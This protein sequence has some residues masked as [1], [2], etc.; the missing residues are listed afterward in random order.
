L[1]RRQ[2]PRVALAAALA[3]VAVLA[4]TAF[5]ATGALTPRGCVDDN[6]TG[7]DDCG[8]ST[9]GLAS[10]AS[11]AASPDGRSVYTA[12]STDNAIV[13]FD[14]DP[15]TG[16][17]TPQGCIEDE[18]V[19]PDDCDQTAPGLEGAISVAVSPDGNSV[20]AASITD[21]AVVRFDRDSSGALTQQGCFDDNDTGADNCGAGNE[22]NG[23]D[24]AASAT[25]SPD[26]KS[27]YV[28]SNVDDAIVRFDRNTSSGALTPQGC[29]DDN[30]TGADNCGVGNETN[31]LDGAV[32]TTV[33]PDNKSVYAVSDTDDAIV[34]FDRSTTTGALTPQGCVDD[35]DTGADDC[36]VGNDADGL[37]GPNSVAVSP[38]NK[39]VYV[40]SFTDNAVVRFGRDLS[41]GAL[42]PQGCI[43][44]D[45][46][47][48]D[49]CT[50]SSEGLTTA[51]TVAVSSDGKSVYAAGTDG[52]ARFDRSTTG[53]LTPAG[54]VEDNDVGPDSCA[55]SSDGLTGATFLTITADAKSVLVA[56]F[57]DNA[58]VRLDREDPPETSITSGPSGHTADNTPTY[59]FSSDESGVSFE[60]RVDGG[61]FA[62][63]SSPSTIGPLPDG[64]HT[65]RVRARDSFGTVD[66]T[67]AQRSVTVDT[68]PG[69]VTV[70]TTPPETTV[71][72]GPKR[73]VKLKRRKK[74]KKARFEFSSSEAGSSFECSLDGTAFE[75]CTSPV[76]EKVKKGR[77]SF[78]VRA[79]DQ[80]GNTDATPAEWLWKVKKKR[81]KKQ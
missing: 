30:D 3:A 56:S 38:D 53:A 6:D 55:Q 50:Q 49:G 5:G 80:L 37:D 33:S 39:S 71:V 57:I 34:R 31:G 74:R 19:G 29:V 67:P 40:A 63:C 61:E 46:T 1:I 44:D 73:T 18:D 66:L 20:Y 59:R 21:D 25:V 58:V 78:D 79:S 54:C 77:H 13:R 10:V 27:V 32:S 70:D 72:S 43:E 75:P 42:T 36:G 51:S 47:G 41:T 12:A 17:L 7:A 16:A 15:S 60:C 45:D 68:R 28:A 64:P 76:T 24:G 9:D 35:N 11:V 2:A 69:P 65:F 81:R 62:A 8:A 26:N 48:P 4:A 52:I 14:R 22:I 23:L